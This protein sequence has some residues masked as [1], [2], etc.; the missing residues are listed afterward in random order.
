MIQVLV[1]DRYKVFPRINQVTVFR[2]CTVQCNFVDKSFLLHVRLYKKALIYVSVETLVSL[3][4]AFQTSNNQLTSSLLTH[5]P[6]KFDLVRQTVLRGGER[7]AAM[8]F[9]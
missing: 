3:Y 8:V 7:R 9:V 2:T 4:I 6:K 5:K 1:E